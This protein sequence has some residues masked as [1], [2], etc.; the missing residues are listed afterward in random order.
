MELMATD[1]VQNITQDEFPPQSQYLT[2]DFILNRTK[3]LKKKLD[4]ANRSKHM[5]LKRTGGGIIINFSTGMFELYRSALLSMYNVT[6]RVD[7]DA[8]RSA[9]F[10][11]VVSITPDDNHT[12]TVQL[13]L[14][15]SKWQVQGDEAYFLD[16]ELS[17][18]QEKVDSVL[19]QNNTDI[20]SVNN[21][22]KE[23]LNQVTQIM[24]ISNKDTMDTE[25]PPCGQESGQ[26]DILVL[27]KALT[28]CTAQNNVQEIQPAVT[29]SAVTSEHQQQ[30][31]SSDNILLLGENEPNSK[32]PQNGDQNALPE[33]CTYKHR[34]LQKRSATKTAAEKRKSGVYSI[35]RS[36]RA[37][38]ISKSIKI[39]TSPKRGKNR[40]S[41]KK[42]L[43]DSE[44]VM[45]IQSESCVESQS[46]K[47]NAT[48]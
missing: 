19:L 16:H 1:G 3:A 39:L 42:A 48:I 32:T 47:Y 9:K 38:A 5:E 40:H 4:A 36:H 18:L 37:R 7:V 8:T 23:V 12:Y 41:S 15:S 30:D 35:V 26:Q 31:T 46:I 21:Q 27:N 45:C 13:L 11:E 43:N 28:T 6:P 14:T 22:M 29:R 33:E 44:L 34:R 25:E 24:D 17:K 2:S 10:R 20:D